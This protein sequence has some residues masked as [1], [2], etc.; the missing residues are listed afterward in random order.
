MKFNTKLFVRFS[1]SSDKTLA[2]C[3][4]C[5]VFPH[6]TLLQQGNTG[7]TIKFYMGLEQASE[8]A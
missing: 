8:S 1:F 2:K 3:Q 5:P 7:H 4:T 6:C